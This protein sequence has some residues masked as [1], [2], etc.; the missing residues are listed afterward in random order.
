MRRGS[1]RPGQQFS[2]QLGAMGAPWKVLDHRRRKEDLLNLP[3]GKKKFFH[4]MCL[5]LIYWDFVGEFKN[6]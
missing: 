4:P 1:A 5:N 3:K 2:L 6:G